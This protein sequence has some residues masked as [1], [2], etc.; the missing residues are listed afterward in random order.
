MARANHDSKIPII[1]ADFRTGAYTIKVLAQKH[2]VSVG[3]VSKHTK[4]LEKDAESIVNAGVVFKQ[5]LATNNEFLVN[6]VHEAVD[7][8]IRLTRFF[9]NATVKNLS[10]MMDK[11]NETTAIAEHR[12]AQQAIKDGKETVL[13][14]TPDTAIQ[15]NNTTQGGDDVT[16][17][18]RARQRDRLG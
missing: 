16:A 5:G 14:K 11:I 12:L 2:R 7:E 8:K 17:R 18:I 15:I 10:T 1:Q 9:S 4:D 6:A 13:G 3:F